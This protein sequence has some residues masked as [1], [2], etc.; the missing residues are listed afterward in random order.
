MGAGAQHEEQAAVSAMRRRLRMTGR[1]EVVPGGHLVATVDGVVVV[2]AHRDPE[3]VTA[4]SAAL[5]VLETVLRLVGEAASRETRRTGRT[6]ARLVSD[7][8]MSRDDEERIEFGVLTPGGRGLAVFLHGGVTAVLDGGDRKEILHG[9]DAGFSVDR[10]VVPPPARAAAIFVDEQAPREELPEPGVW[11]L[12]EG[13]MPGAGAVVWLGAE[14]EKPSGSGAAKVRD[15][16]TRGATSGKGKGTE[17]GE[18]HRPTPGNGKDQTGT[19][20]TGETS[21]EEAGTGQTSEETRTADEGP[22]ETRAAA[23]LAGMQWEKPPRP[24]RG[25]IVRGYEC[26]RHHLND[27][28]VMSCAVCGYRIDQLSGV[29]T[30]G[31]RPPLGVLRLDDGNCFTLDADLVIGREPDRS[32]QVRHGARPIRIEDSSGGMS[33]VHAEVRLVDWDVLVLDRGSANGTH[34]RTPGRPEWMRATPG[35]PVIVTAGCQILLG[36]RIFTLDAQW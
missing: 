31:V 8:V 11:A 12:S 4:D 22:G 25:V 27:P 1:V 36:G 7:W 28:R 2:V 23:G 10:M 13:R 16:R 34:I 26:P 20:G 24:G 35:H 14:A 3:P 33:R 19:K 32:T 15:T 9:R 17:S 18:G 30:E 29:L 21:A 6:F 5:S